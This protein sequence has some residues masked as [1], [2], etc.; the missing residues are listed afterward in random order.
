LDDLERALDQTVGYL[1]SPAALFALDADAYW[2]K[3]DGPWW[4][5]LLLHEM[6]LTHETPPAIVEKL[7]ESLDR[8]LLT[9]FPF[10]V[11]DVP[12]GK[13]PAANVPCHCQLGCV[14]QVLHACGVDVDAR[15]PWIRPWFL[16]Y[17]LPDGGLNCDE[18]A[19]TKPVPRSSIVSTLPP[20]E[21]VLLGT[22]RAFTSEETRFLDRGAQYLIE[23]RL[24][25]SVSR[26][27]AVIDE[28]WGKLCF[29]RF[30][31]YDL[32]RALT[33]LVRYAKRLDR[34]LPLGAME[35]GLR[36]I[37][38]QA[39]DGELAPGRRAFEGTKT[40][41]LAEDGIWRR[42]DSAREAG[43]FPLLEAVS[44]VGAPSPFLS[45]DFEEVRRATG[46]TRDE[47]H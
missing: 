18:V 47:V 34:P 42:G 14:Y 28:A 35:E 41:W 20:L 19:Y 21:A 13:D 26:G 44:V 10:R 9:T 6:G 2:P 4:R 31:F 27:G 30:Y 7:V 29:P 1:R 39:K 43:S 15:L 23:R 16:R 37:R 40:R 12:P 8:H 11:E 3:W 17:Q 22:D 45:R 24:W 32:L 33:F 46:D 38:N 25:R 36:I 5:M